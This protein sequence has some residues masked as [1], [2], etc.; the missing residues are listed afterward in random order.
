V[1]G[2]SR[3]ETWCEGKLFEQ[4]GLNRSPSRARFKDGRG[5]RRFS[6][7]RSAYTAVPGAQMGTPGGLSWSTEAKMVA[8]VARLKS[9]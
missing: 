3:V 6:I 9:A 2:R 4:L 7:T 8:S 1:R 5:R